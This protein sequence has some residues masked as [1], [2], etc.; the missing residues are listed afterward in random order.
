MT[1]PLQ[2][3]Q[4]AIVDHEPVDRGP[5]AGY[6]HGKGPADDRA[7]LYIVAEGTT[8]A[9]E[10]FAGHIVSGAGQLWAGLDISLTGALQRLFHEAHRNLAD[11]NRKSIAQHRV[12]I[13][14]SAFG[15]RG[16]QAVI[17]QAGPSVAFHA[18]GGRVIPYYTDEEH[19][20]P[21][22]SGPLEPQLTRINFLPGDR[23]LLLST[24]ALA[25]CDD[26][27]IAGILQLPVDQVLPELWRRL[28]DARHLTVLL[29]TAP[30]GPA[31]GA[32]ASA[33]ASP[34]NL[35]AASA[36]EMVIGGEPASRETPAPSRRDTPRAHGITPLALTLEPA[37]DAFQP[38]LFIEE[39]QEDLV[40]VARAQLTS[41]GTRARR[42]AYLPMESAEA[43]E[44]LRRAVGENVL[45]Q[46]AADGMARAAASR[47]AASRTPMPAL[48]QL[49]TATTASAHPLS[50]RVAQPAPG[51]ITIAPSNGGGSNG[52][53][54]N[55]A[56]P[57]GLPER[58]QHRRRQQ[59]FSRGLVREE[60]PPPP[61]SHHEEIP[62]AAELAEDVRARAT[63][64]SVAGD[65]IAGENAVTI[66]GG[67]SLVRVRSKPSGRWK[68]SSS[69]GGGARTAL[70][71]LP[72]TWLIILAG[73]TVLVAVVG[74]I[75]LPGMLSKDEGER[76]ASLIDQA[77]QKIAVARSFSQDPAE[78]R[79][80][81]TEAQALLLEARDLSANGPEAESLISEVAGALS[82]MDAVKTPA[83]VETIASLEQFGEKPVA[84][85]RLTVSN[86][87]AYI[88]DSASGQ[89]IAIK[90]ADGERKVVYGEDKDAKRGRPIATTFTDGNDLGG[91]A[92]LVADD[93]RGLWAV[94]AAGGLKPV[95][96]AA[97]AGLKITD[98][99]MFGRDLFVLDS[100]AS[101]IY[102]FS[103]SDGGYNATPFKWLDTPDLAGA[104][105]LMVDGEAITVDT[106]G[107]VRRF[108]G[109]LSLVMSEAGIDK[110]LVAPET[111]VLA[112]KND[113]AL[114]DA[115]NDRVVVFRRD[116]SF[117][118]Q[119]RHPDFKAMSAFTM[120]NG[121]AYVFSG[122]KLRRVTF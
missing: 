65:T 78:R 14:L 56:V 28:Q 74:F 119:Y 15:R 95:P 30:D 39:K 114:L 90:L 43:P 9:G 75:A 21:L 72:P 52:T 12:S 76:Y 68:G 120:R 80:V 25:E 36:P 4:F 13:G 59:S 35:P 54:A 11:W 109:Q 22:G 104:R 5:N 63:V 20:R 17:A 27:L 107:S 118:R 88:L 96:F 122:G 69:G 6:F 61:P 73:L 2:V 79:R 34:A 71:G 50:W 31:R 53:P 91:P 7:E 83:A 32:R 93:G 117:D 1:E 64:A 45:A 87:A 116:G 42:A 38:S 110:K 48:P 111:P 100:T 92:L 101:I 85:T 115:A 112:G 82:V 29:V 84:A 18:T 98:I 26:E 97:P 19:G 103:P 44:P 60:V 113:I 55:D 23:L 99:T 89:V 8:P 105:R 49:A 41:I 106:N 37:D 57:G 121:V 51:P 33:I 47:A 70:K 108:S 46:L 67:G 86:D 102:R 58:R 3:G 10:A 94:T 16:P 24:V 40:A 62:L 81:L 77:E 66:N